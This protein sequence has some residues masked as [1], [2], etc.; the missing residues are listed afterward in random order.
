MDYQAIRVGLRQSQWFLQ[1][2]EGS[3]RVRS[4]WCDRSLTIVGFEEGKGPGAKEFGQ[5]I[6]LGMEKIK[7]FP[8]AS[9]KE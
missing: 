8:R 3:R 1:V 9:R 4:E 2:K 6:K 7:F 5:P